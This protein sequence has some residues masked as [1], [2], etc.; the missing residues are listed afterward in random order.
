MKAFYDKPLGIAAPMRQSM[1]YNQGREMAIHKELGRRMNIAV[2]FCDRHSP[3]QHGSNE[4]TNGLVRQY[5][6]KGTDFS[7]YSQEKMD[8]IAEQINNRPR[9]GLSV[10]FPLAVYR[11]NAC[12]T[13]RNTPPSFIE[14]QGVALQT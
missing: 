11:H 1:T 10:R 3:W 13:A 14:P 8:A 6:A 7:S 2:H 4:K 12:S 9:K 5:L